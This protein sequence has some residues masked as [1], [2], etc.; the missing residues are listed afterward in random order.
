M[1][2]AFVSQYDLD[3]ALHNQAGLAQLSTI[4]FAAFFENRFMLKEL[5][6]KGII[7]GIPTKSG[8]FSTS[9]HAFGPAKWAENTFSIG[10]SKQLTPK[11][12]GG[13]QLNYFGMKL[14]EENQ[15]LYSVGAELGFIY[16]LSPTLFVGAHLANPVSIP[17]KTLSYNDKIPWRFRLGGHSPITEDLTLAV[18]AEKTENQNIVLKAG[19]E[20]KVVERFYLRGGYNSGA[21]KLITGIGF[22]YRS[23]TADI[24]F[25]YH[26]TLGV[27]PSVSIKVSLK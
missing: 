7:I 15:S 20:W 16:R 21:T 6:S 27:T 26:Q 14:P 2:N 19:M 9:M 4:S 8:V 17:F 12:S 5:S 24:A 11:L 10:Y 23:I 18:E 3:A 1:G 25:G 22:S 13:I